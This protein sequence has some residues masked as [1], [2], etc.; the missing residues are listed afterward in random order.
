MLLERDNSTRIVAAASAAFLKRQGWW[1]LVVVTCK[2]PA[3]A[4]AGKLSSTAGIVSTSLEAPRMTNDRLQMTKRFV[5][6][7]FGQAFH[8][9]TAFGAGY[10]PS[11]SSGQARAFLGAMLLSLVVFEALEKSA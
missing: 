8:G 10:D 6:G 4:S 1:Q 2:F 5:L 11:V 9:P 7:P 3:R